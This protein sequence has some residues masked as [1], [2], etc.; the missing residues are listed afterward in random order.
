MRERREYITGR[1]SKR[2]LVKKVMLINVFLALILLFAAFFMPDS[3]DSVVQARTATI[4]APVLTASTTNFTPINE[5]DVESAGTT[6]ATLLK[7]QIRT[8]AR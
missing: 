2:Y 4:S 6:V 5:N 1:Y 8:V 7:P 3:P